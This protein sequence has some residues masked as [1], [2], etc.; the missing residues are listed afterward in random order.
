MPEATGE[1]GLDPGRQWMLA[2]QRGDDAAFTALVRHYGARIVAFFRRGGAD[3][4]AAEDLAQEALLRIARAR[5]RYEPTAK[6]TTWLH[7]ILFRIALNDAARNRWRRAVGF[8]ANAGAPEP[9]AEE[10]EGPGAALDRSELREAVRAAVA[11]LPEP[12]RTALLLH[13]FEHCPYDEVAATL[14]LSLAALKSLLFRARENLKRRL[15]PRF[16]EVDHGL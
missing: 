13:R 12:Q 1:G 3:A 5:D 15:A 7:R 6:F 8:D 11:S 2:F 4:A 16:D 14:G 9:A 10:G